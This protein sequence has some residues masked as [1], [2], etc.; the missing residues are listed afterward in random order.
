M[1]QQKLTIRKKRP[2]K[3][4]KAAAVAM[5][6]PAAIKMF[7]LAVGVEDKHGDFAGCLPL[8]FVKPG[9]SFDQF[10]PEAPALFRISLLRLDRNAL[11]HHL[12]DCLRMMAQIVIPT[13]MMR[14]ATV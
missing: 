4:V 5:T 12:D 14:L 6:F 13:R 7:L 9:M 10:G 3:M 2:A 8:V 11:I 1:L